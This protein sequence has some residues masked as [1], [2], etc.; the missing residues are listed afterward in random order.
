M[1]ALVIGATGATGKELIE[2]LLRDSDFDSVHAFSRRP[3]DFSDPKL[4]VD[5]VDFERPQDWKS[6]LKGDVAFSCLGTTLKAA[7]GKLS[8]RKVDFDYQLDFAKGCR[9]NEVPHFVLISSYGANQNSKVF[10][11]KMKGELEEEIRALEFEKLTIFQPGMLE[12]KM[13]DRPGEVLGASVLK[14]LNR[15]HLL[16]KLRPLQTSTLAQAMVYSAK[17]KSKGESV[18]SLASI[19]SLAKKP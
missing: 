11:S 15:L 19:F 16:R 8:Q 1:K 14:F 2:E 12:R 17:I 13:S 10:Y 5:I 6:Q 9:E 18:I 3:L 7:G 4:H